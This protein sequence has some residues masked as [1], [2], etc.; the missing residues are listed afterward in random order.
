M[1]LPY[2]LTITVLGVYP[3]ETKM[4]VHKNNSY[5]NINSSI[6][7]NSPRK[8]KYSLTGKWIKKLGYIQT[9]EYH[10]SLKRDVLLLHTPTGMNLQIIMLSERNQTKV[11]A[12]WFSVWNDKKKIKLIYSNRKKI[13][14]H[15][16]SNGG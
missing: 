1:Y 3:R 5:L 4:R 2:G 6:I 12:V 15:L 10:T 7:Q 14:D 8:W 9:M 11:H 16:G 13:T